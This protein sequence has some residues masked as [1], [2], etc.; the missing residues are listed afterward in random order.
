MITACIWI[1]DILF[2]YAFISCFAEQAKGTAILCLIIAVAAYV[3]RPFILP[4]IG[5]AY[6]HYVIIAV[7]TV[8]MLKKSGSLFDTW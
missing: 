7:L 1:L 8:Y 2:L 4:Y 6:I 5:I 3:G